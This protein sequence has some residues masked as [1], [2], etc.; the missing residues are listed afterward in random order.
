MITFALLVKY[1]EVGNVPFPGCLL[2]H[3]IIQTIERT[4]NVIS[5]NVDLK[6]KFTFTQSSGHLSRCHRASGTNLYQRSP[7]HQSVPICTNPTPNKSQ[8]Q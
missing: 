7:P 5:G 6:P 1:D 8:R 3:Y 2:F 4:K